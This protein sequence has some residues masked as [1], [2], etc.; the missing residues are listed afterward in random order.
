MTFQ[1]QR[2]LGS[3]LPSVITFRVRPLRSSG[4]G[5]G[6]VF[7]LCRIT[8]AHLEATWV[9]QLSVESHFPPG[10]VGSV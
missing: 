5:G 3:P 1:G 6:A 7:H 8:E 10:A 4:P 2:F 9:V